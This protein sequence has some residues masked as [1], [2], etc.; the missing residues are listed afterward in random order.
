L[1]TFCICFWSS[2]TILNRC[3]LIQ[4][5]FCSFFDQALQDTTAPYKK[6]ESNKVKEK[7]QE[8]D[9]DEEKEDNDEK[10]DDKKEEDNDKQ[11]KKDQEKDQD[12][13]KTGRSTRSIKKEKVNL[14]KENQHQTRQK[15]LQKMDESA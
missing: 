14:Q 9:D 7:Q 15:E 3:H 10:E 8:K 12:D 4:W 1:E 2:F 5:S 13:K 11:D 6:I